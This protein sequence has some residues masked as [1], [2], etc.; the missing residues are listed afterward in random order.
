MIGFFVLDL[1]FLSRR[2]RGFLGLAV[3]VT[4]TT[5]V[6]VGGLVWQTHFT[7]N[8]KIVVIDYSDSNYGP[9]AAMYFFYYFG[10]ASYQALAYWIMGTISNDP[11]TLA[12]FTGLYKC[13]QSAG[14][15]G[16][17]GMDAVA[18]PFLNEIV[19]N[20]FL[21][22][23]RY[24]IKLNNYVHPQTQLASWLLMMVSFPLA[25]LVIY[26]I[27]ETSYTEEKTVFVDE[28]HAQT[29]EGHLHTGKLEVAGAKLE[30]VDEKA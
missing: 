30:S 15:A 6:W 21:T 8:S 5:A 2:K 4:C 9:K 28:S 26:N 12:R 1:P 22:L 3:L 23:T 20:A 27:K 18:T 25:G 10:D 17:F 7:R 19:S 11:F 13:I 14:A 16:S 29:V 24:T